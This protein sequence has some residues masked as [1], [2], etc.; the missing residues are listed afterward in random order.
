MTQ[1]EAIEVRYRLIKF[2]T[3]I[4]CFSN[5]VFINCISRSPISK[6]F[7]SFWPRDSPLFHLLHVP[8][9]LLLL[10]TLRISLFRLF[11][12]NLYLKALLLVEV[13]IFFFLSSRYRFGIKATISTTSITYRLSFEDSPTLVAEVPY[14][15]IDQSTGEKHR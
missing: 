4:I 8:W 7:W 6:S 12:A 10:I 5:F 9:L 15:L 14:G 11:F 2:L 3:C 1:I 13:Y